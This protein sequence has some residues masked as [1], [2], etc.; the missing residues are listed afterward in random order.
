MVIAVFR[1]NAQNSIKLPVILLT[2]AALVFGF[3]CV[4]MFQKAPMV[5]HGTGMTDMVSIG[6]EQTCCGGGMSQ[7]MQSWTNTFLATPHDLWGSLSFILA[8]LLTIIF[9]RSLFK[10]TNLDVPLLSSKL[11]LQQNPYF[12]VLDPLKQALADGIL[13]TKLY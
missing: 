1:I 2:I 12:F 9:T 13:N 7:N 4:D 8:F 5:M 6:G 3:F 11:Y 10:R